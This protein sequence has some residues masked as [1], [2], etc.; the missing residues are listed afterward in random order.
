[1]FEDLFPQ[2]DYPDLSVKLQIKQPELL[3]IETKT[4][5]GRTFGCDQDWYGH[6][7]QRQAGCGPCTAATLLFYLAHRHPSLSSLY[8]A[9]SGSQ[10]DFCHFMG[11]IWHYVTPGRMGVNE[12]RILS[13]GVLSFASKQLVNLKASLNKV[14]GLHQ[15]RIPLDEVITFI[16]QGL[17]HDSPVAFL[18]L[19]NG[20]LKNLESWHWVTITALY[21]AGN[22]EIMAMISD[23]GEA[24]VINLSQWYASSLLGGSFVYF[25]WPPFDRVGP[26]PLFDRGT[27]HSTVRTV[28]YTALPK[29]TVY[30][31]E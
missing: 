20:N 14:A 12:G 1:M 22:K 31:L 21:L 17:S 9:S 27:S 25:E 23:S 7:W 6:A 28:R 16:E 4:P 24:K 19:S 18:N 11:E 30:E 5:P 8:T 2:T 29:F 3:F 10:D 15:P 26:R 13:E